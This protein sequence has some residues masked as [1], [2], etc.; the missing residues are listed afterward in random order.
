MYFNLVQFNR[1]LYLPSILYSAC[2]VPGAV[3]GIWDL[4]VNTAKRFVPM[5]LKLHSFI[6]MFLDF[7]W[8]IEENFGFA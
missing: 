7:V 1:G 2:P 3:L 6:R 8:Q 4:S 5:E